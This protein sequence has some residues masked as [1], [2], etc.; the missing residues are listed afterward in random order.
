MTWLL[1]TIVKFIPIGGFYGL[2][3]P[4]RSRMT[5]PYRDCVSRCLLVVG[6]GEAQPSGYLTEELGQYMSY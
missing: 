1:V 3:Y 2:D 6:G 4:Y 5:A